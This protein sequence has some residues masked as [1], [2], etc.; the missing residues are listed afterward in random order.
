MNAEKRPGFEWR[1]PLD[2]SVARK[3]AS[4]VCHLKAPTVRTAARHCPF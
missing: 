3:I 2:G 1:N 4:G